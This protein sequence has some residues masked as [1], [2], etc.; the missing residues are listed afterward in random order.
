MNPLP[1]TFRWDGFEFRQLERVGRFAVF[2]KRKGALN[3]SFEVV[4]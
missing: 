4:N 1:G 2:E 3:M